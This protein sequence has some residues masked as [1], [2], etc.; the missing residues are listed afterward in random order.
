MSE[1]VATSPFAGELFLMLAT[2]GRLIVDEAS[3]E[4]M[5]AGLERTL[6]L[7]RARLRVTRI[8]YRQPAG[9]IEE[10]L[11]VL[12]GDVVE[13]LFTD[14]MAPGHLEQAAAELPKYIEALRRAQRPQPNAC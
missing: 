11:D 3:A 14:Q 1:D 12:A 2:E 5:I 6:T 4:R 13:A 7:V 10:L 9:R 8:W